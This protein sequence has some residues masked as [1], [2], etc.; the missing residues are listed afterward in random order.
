MDRSVSERYAIVSP[1]SPDELMGGG[2]SADRSVV[3]SGSYDEML[4]F[5]DDRGWLDGLPVVPPTAEAVAAMLARS[6]FD[7]SEALGVAGPLNRLATV[8]SAAVNAVMAG[9]RPE[10]FP[11]LLAVVRALLSPAFRLQDAGS[12]TGWEPLAV[13]SGAGLAGRGFNSGSGVMRVG[14]RPNTSLGRFVRLWMRNVAGLRTPPGETDVCA[15][16]QTF[17]LPLVEAE[18][19]TRELGWPTLRE[20]WGFPPHMEA[21]SVQGIVAASPPI[22]TT[23]GAAQAH[24]PGLAAGISATSA[25]FLGV[26]VANQSWWPVLALSPAIAAVFARAGYGPREV[27]ERIAAQAWVPAHQL[28]DGMQGLLQHSLDLADLVRTGVAPPAYHRNDDPAR[29]VPAVPDPAALSVVIT[30]SPGRN[31]SRF[32]CPVGLAGARVAVEV[33][34]L[35]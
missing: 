5:L 18:T 3:F 33:T 31:Q 23:G 7:G 28:E 15:I 21:V 11:L 12:T 35:A 19:A 29:L 26:G 6:P 27:A 24:V 9:A 2:L 10:D 20:Q 25:R 1:V 34:S 16:G 8:W 4:A 14:P 13:L 30:G 32:Y 17:F 22:Y